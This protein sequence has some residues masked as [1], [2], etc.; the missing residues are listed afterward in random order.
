MTDSREARAREFVKNLIA[1]AQSPHTGSLE[2]DLEAWPGTGI[3]QEELE[4]RVFAA[5]TAEAEL[6]RREALEQAAH[7]VEASVIRGPDGSEV[8]AFSKIKR[9][10]ASAIRALS[11][12]GA[13]P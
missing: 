4:E 9:N 7:W 5:L 2:G 6:A 13:K 11:H 12:T 10:M 1:D 3:T 8:P